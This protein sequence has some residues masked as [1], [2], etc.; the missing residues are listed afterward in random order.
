MTQETIICPKCAHEQTNPV[1]CE[2]C[3]L[4]FR[5]YQQAQE[6]NM[7][8]PPSPPPE[9]TPQSNSSGAAGRIGSALALAAVAAALTY[10]L[11][12]GKGTQ[13]A[14]PPAPA[15]PTEAS[16]T[17]APPVAEQPQTAPPASRPAPAMVAGSPIEQAKNGT[18]AI[19]APWGKGSGFFVTDTAIVTNKHVVEPDR[20]QLGEIRHKVETGRQLLGLERQNIAELR[21][22]LQ[23]M[24]DSPTR[25]QL[26][27]ILQ[28]KERQLAQV[29]PTQDEAEARLKELEKPKSASDIKVFLADGSEYSVNSS[30]VS[31]KRDLALLSIYSSK[32]APLKPAP[33]NSGLRQGDKVFTIGNPV[34]LRNTVTAGIFSGYR[35]HKDTGEIM[36]QTDAPINPGNSGGP[37]IDERGQVHGVNTMI[38]QNTQGI[39][40]AIPI[41]VV[42]DEF[43]ITPP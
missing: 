16:Q 40:F 19:E 24:D 34:G 15:P 14:P 4:L 27:I 20:S 29:Q 21:N 42:F 13:T 32:A 9:E 10:F 41:Q 26:V 17:T 23:Q 8:Q 3:G 43:S 38:I 30:Q 22:R 37:L 7:E 33:K 1:E 12:A 5:R 28:E 25:R 18:V 11:V 2:A 35:Q 39:G 36:L 31:A 6:R